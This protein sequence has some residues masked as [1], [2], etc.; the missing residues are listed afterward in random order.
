MAIALAGTFTS[1]NQA[2]SPRTMAHNNTGDT[3][4]VVAV[5]TTGVA[6]AATY[7]AVSMTL[8]Q[9]Q[10]GG[11]DHGC[12][13]FVLVGAASGTHDVVV[14]A[15]GDVG[16]IAQSFTGVGSAV[17]KGG[18][19]HDPPTSP[20]LH[21]V[22]SAAGNLVVDGTAFFGTPSGESVSGANT[23][24]TVSN[25]SGSSD[26]AMSYAAGSASVAM[27]W[28]FAVATPMTETAIDLIPSGT[29]GLMWL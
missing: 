28:S 10:D 3:V 1:A 6:S 9:N 15:T 4:V 12:T 2:T 8:V 14:T 17:G 21:T 24:I 7:N 16:I 5:S 19:F 26:Q 11:G 20:E 25:S 23:L 27:Q 13:I 18:F 22:V 29:G